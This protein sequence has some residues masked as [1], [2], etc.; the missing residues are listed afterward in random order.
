VLLAS[1]KVRPAALDLLGFQFCHA[2]FESALD[3]L[4]GAG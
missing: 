4:L 1:Q 2:D 3:D